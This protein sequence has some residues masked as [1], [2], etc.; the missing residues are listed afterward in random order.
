MDFIVGSPRI[1]RQHDSIMA[2][3]DRLTKVVHFILLKSTFSR[4]MWHKYLLGTWLDCMEFQGIL[5]QKGMRISL[6]SF[7]RSYL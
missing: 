2:I 4:V 6:P 1:V 3:V 5:C 7:G